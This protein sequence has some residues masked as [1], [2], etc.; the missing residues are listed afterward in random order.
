MGNFTWAGALLGVGIDDR[1]EEGLFSAVTSV[2]K[3]PCVS[4]TGKLAESQ[5]GRPSAQ[6]PGLERKGRPS[7]RRE[8][9]SLRAISVSKHGCGDLDPRP[10]S[11]TLKALP[12]R[13]NGPRIDTPVGKDH[14]S[15]ETS[16]PAG[17]QHTHTHVSVA[18]VP[19][20]DSLCPAADA[21]S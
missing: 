3:G 1:C 9:V 2:E 14:D 17:N 5:A 21:A 6:L 8:R 10:T 19:R 18:G 13:S 15:H 20:V 16:H 12:C 11:Q 7:Q 4:W